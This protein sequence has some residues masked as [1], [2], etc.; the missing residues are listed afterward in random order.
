MRPA[1]TGTGAGRV[2]GGGGAGVAVVGLVGLLGVADGLADGD[3]VAVA[4]VGTALAV[5]GVVVAV[6]A[7]DVTWVPVAVGW[8]DPPPAAG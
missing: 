3:G 6:E 7:G 8:V 2:V 4:V 5:G 1:A